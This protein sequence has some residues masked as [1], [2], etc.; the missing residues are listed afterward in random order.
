MMVTSGGRNFY[1]LEETIT[2]RDAY[3]GTVLWARR[4][5]VPSFEEKAGIKVPQQGLAKRN[6]R[7][8]PVAVGDELYAISEGEILV[9]DAATGATRRVL[10]VVA[11]PH[12]LLVEGSRLVVAGAEGLRAYD[13]A[14]G[15][16]AWETPLPARRMVA[17]DGALFCIAGDGAV[18]LD[19]AS[20]R[21]RWRS[22]DADAGKAGTCTYHQ[23]VLVLELSTW[24]NFPD[25]CGLLALSARDGATLW[26]KL[27]APKMTHRLE[28]RALF[29]QGLLWINVVEGYKRRLIGLDPLTSQERKSWGQSGGAHCTPPLATERFLIAPECHFTDF[30]TGQCDSARMA[31]HA[32]RIP[33][34]PANGLL[35]TFPLQCECFPMLRG[36]MALASGPTPGIQPGPLLR[37]APTPAPASANPNDEWPMY[38]HDVYR[39]GSTPCKVPAGSLRTRWQTDVVTPV[40]GL[41][42]DEWSANPFVR[43]PLT[44]PVAA[45]GIV[46]VAAPDA[47]RVV[48]LDAASG[49]VRW[50]FTTG[51][52]VDTPP[53]LHAGLCLFGGHD[54]WV[55]ALD[56]STG[57]LVWRYRAAPREARIVAYGQLES[58]WPV[59]GSVLVDGDAAYVVAGRQAMSDGGVYVHALRPRTG[60]LLWTQRVTDLPLTRWYGGKLES[61][62]RIKIGLNFKPVDLPVRDGDRIAMSRWRFD[63]A[64]GKPQA[65]MNSV[66]YEAFDGLRVP[67]GLWDYGSAQAKYPEDRPAVFDA[68]G[69]IVGEP[70][71]VALLLAG[72]IRLTATAEGEL[73]AD[74]RGTLRLGA[75]A[76]HD[77]LIAAYG[78][79]YLS[80]RSGAVVCVEGGNP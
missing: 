17:G 66:E 65:A 2:A 45:G 79:V 14:A 52:R 76:V 24:S 72:G 8:H 18:C 44:P 40:D 41:L 59:A 30:A 57:G 56:A 63:P 60:D 80:T 9:L 16:V 7:V 23:G 32:C 74:G 33:F 54:G 39:G 28:A 22:H 15:R 19:L 5:Q 6:S 42:A 71:E 49:K 21:E 77:G 27:Y 10:G 55:Y 67:C 68:D 62:D 46:V 50:T 29:A 26:K 11:S 64:T 61:N 51:G 48:A 78:R 25:G 53:T 43:G 69:V 20:G 58:P 73:R 13:L 31:R 12:E 75:A 36:V 1:N 47:H 37:A 70:G 35:Y 4:L 3:N 34:V 38:R